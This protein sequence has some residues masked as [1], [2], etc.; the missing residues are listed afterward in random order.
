[1]TSSCSPPAPPGTIDLANRRAADGPLFLATDGWRLDRHG[2]R[3][4][5]RVTY[6]A[7]IDKHVSPGWGPRP[8]E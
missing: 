4:V 6:R 1:M 3:T 5:W 8:A 7:G 2:A